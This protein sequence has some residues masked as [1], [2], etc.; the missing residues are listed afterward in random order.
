MMLLAVLSGFILAL[1]EPGLFRM[2]GRKTG[3]LLSVF[4]VTL[5]LY[6]AQFTTS[7]ASGEKL[8][9]EY[10]WVSNLGVHLNFY[11]DGLSLLFV[12]LICGIG[13]LVFF[14]SGAYLTHH[15][16]L[17]RFYSFLLLFM[18]SM[19]GLVLADN[20]IALFIFW[21]LTSISSYLLIGFDHKR[22]E[23]RSAALQALLVTGTGGLA[24][25]AGL[26]LLGEAGGSL[27]ISTLASLGDSIRLH[28]LYTPI[29]LLVLAGAFTKSAQVP[30]HF[31]LP[32]AME[33]PTPVSTYL[34]AATMVKAGI[35]LLARFTPILGGTELWMHLVLPV[36]GFTM[37]TGAYLALM[38]TDLKRILA[39]TTVSALGIL[40][41]LLGLGSTAAIQAALV[42]LLAHALY[43]GALFL[44]AG[45]LDHETGTRE[46]ERLG[47]L[48]QSMPITALAAGLAALSSAGFPPFLGFVG[49]ELM[50]QATL[51]T[52]QAYL[53]TGAAVL[54][55]ASFVTAAGIVG[56]KPFFGKRTPFLREP[57]EAPFA[58]W[59]GPLLLAVLGA[60]FG[61]KPDLI[62]ERLIAPAL[63]AIDAQAI[64]TE[65]VLWHGFD[66]KL[67][68]SVGVFLA[69]ITLYFGWSGI[70]RTLI[71]LDSSARWGPNQWYY[72]S[73]KVLEGICRIQTRFLQSGHLHLYLL[74]VIMSTIVL[75]GSRL[76]EQDVLAGFWR[77][78]DLRPYEAM[79]AGSI[80][81]AAL[82]VVRS[83][84]RLT[85]VVAL[86][87]V[88]YGV[89]LVFLLFSAPDLAMTQF[90]I[91]TLS[92]VL[93]VLV[94]FRL[95]R[96]KAY[97]TKMERTRDAAAALVSGGLFTALIL[98]A[99]AIE[100]EAR[101]VPYFAENALELARGRNVVNVILVDFRGFDTLGEITVLSVAAVGVYA[102]L[103]LKAG[104]TGEEKSG[105]FLRKP[106]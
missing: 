61:L 44:V 59:V 2:T 51:S 8:A 96:F 89:A 37:L 22:E 30:F 4:P 33:A 67:L 102:L 79:L 35:Y 42:L 105:K 68:L 93:L 28:P 83:K 50:Y 99:T 9:F 24:L 97:S 82:M 76:P 90:S 106:P 94:I 63:S 104:K 14:Y 70:R 55:S 48:L 38:H 16:E 75:V 60:L 66:P 85:A 18:A 20:G 47:G 41:L 87:V 53:L 92:V 73:L 34:H 54:A 100:R 56:F 57:H 98:A 80:L 39:Y 49:K 36:G 31:W 12:F 65:V 81:M 27:E 103:K 46:A 101:L 40:T 13:T 3:W 25:L 72:A 10:P 11:L 95:P 71:P 17:S 26:L 43:K 52:S 84:S 19:L 78:M 77:W 23:A 74:I 91:E 29:L 7:I 5:M 88:G 32:N 21:E 64:F 6:F 15:P 58:L 45:I 62:S 69:G 1:A 86:G